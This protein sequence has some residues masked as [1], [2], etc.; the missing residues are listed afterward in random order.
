MEACFVYHLNEQFLLY[1]HKIMNVWCVEDVRYAEHCISILAGSYYIVG[2]LNGKLG[3]DQGMATRARQH[4][5]DS[6]WD[7]ATDAFNA[8]KFYDAN[9]ERLTKRLEMEECLQQSMNPF[10]ATPLKKAVTKSI[11]GKQVKINNAIVPL[12]TTSK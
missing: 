2:G 12:M 11:E 10:G 1:N 7:N 3:G 8:Q 6:T 4:S 9:Y 5:K